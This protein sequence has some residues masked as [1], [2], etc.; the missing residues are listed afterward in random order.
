MN[1]NRARR[2]CATDAK[3][4]SVYCGDVVLDSFCE[5]HKVVGFELIDADHAW[6]VNEKGRLIVPHLAEKVPQGKG[7][8]HG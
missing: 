6:I 4:R 2:L 7:M 3:G 8:Q 5:Q 1:F